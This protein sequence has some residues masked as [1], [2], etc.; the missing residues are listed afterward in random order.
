MI[1][2][3]TRKLN[4]VGM[5]YLARIVGDQVSGRHR[6]R[7]HPAAPGMASRTVARRSLENRAHVACNALQTHVRP[8]QGITCLIMGETF[9]IGL[10][11]KDLHRSE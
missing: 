9:R 10:F 4:G 3:H 6:N 2:M 11:G 7:I 8:G 1:E 5:A